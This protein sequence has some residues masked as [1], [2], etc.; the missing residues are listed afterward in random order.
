MSC[1][2]CV[3]LNRPNIGSPTA[4]MMSS[5]AEKPLVTSVMSL[6]RP[7]PTNCLMKLMP[8]APGKKKYTASGLAARSWASSVA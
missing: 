8:M 1:A 2:Q 7:A 5:S 3:V 4:P 6:D